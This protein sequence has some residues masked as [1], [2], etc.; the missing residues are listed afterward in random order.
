MKLF[1][2]FFFA[3]RES[4]LTTALERQRLGRTMPGQTGAMAGSRYG[5]LVN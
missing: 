5:F 1:S 2:R 4:N 3:R